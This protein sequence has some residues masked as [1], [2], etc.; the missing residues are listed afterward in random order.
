MA[1]EI[2]GRV[3]QRQLEKRLLG[4]LV[5]EFWRGVRV[6]SCPSDILAGVRQKNGV[7]YVHSTSYGFNLGS[8][9]V[10]DPANGQSGDGAFRVSR[11]LPA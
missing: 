9:L 4:G 6:Y 11:A 1:V 7:D 10:F 3:D 8:W 2:S 5:G